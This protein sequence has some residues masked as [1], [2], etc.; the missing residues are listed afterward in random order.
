MKA[1]VKVK[2]EVG[3]KGKIKKVIEIVEGCDIVN[4]K[5]GDQLEVAETWE[6]LLPGT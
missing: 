6:M 4:L 1:K 5:V 3:E 2:V